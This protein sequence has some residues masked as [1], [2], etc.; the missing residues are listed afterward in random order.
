MNSDY[1]RLASNNFLCCF[2]S[3]TTIEEHITIEQL[4]RSL[5]MQLM[6][7]RYEM[8]ELKLT[9]RKYAQAG[10]RDR[11]ISEL[12]MYEIQSVKYKQMIDIFTKARLLRDSINDAHNM[13]EITNAM[14]YANGNHPIRTID[15]AQVEQ[16]MDEWSDTMQQTADVSDVLSYNQQDYDEIMD[17]EFVIEMPSVPTHQPTIKKTRTKIGGT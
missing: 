13:V 5:E 11:A 3:T 1:Q 10:D 7:K 15:E 8:V 17:P 4:V 14:S 2:P 6:A 9:A 16:L 12:K